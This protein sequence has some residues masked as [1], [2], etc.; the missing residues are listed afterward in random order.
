MKISYDLEAD[1]LSIVFRDT[2]VTTREW[3]EG[4]TGEYD[5]QG[6]LA[7]IEILDAK[8]RLGDVSSLQNIVFEGVGAS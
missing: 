5:S 2:T 4:V 3:A 7:G 6:H 1:A 8:E